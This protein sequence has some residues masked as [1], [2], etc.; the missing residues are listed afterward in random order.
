[1]RGL[2]GFRNVSAVGR[3]LVPDVGD[4]VGGSAGR[5]GGVDTAFLSAIYNRG[6]CRFLGHRW[7]SWIETWCEQYTVVSD[8]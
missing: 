8:K 5:T 7:V 2:R 1:L 6:G 3:G 4:E